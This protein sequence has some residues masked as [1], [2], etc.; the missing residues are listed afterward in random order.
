MSRVIEIDN[1]LKE[2]DIDPENKKELEKETPAEDIDGKE[3][4]GT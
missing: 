3:Q 2:K 1:E 4:N